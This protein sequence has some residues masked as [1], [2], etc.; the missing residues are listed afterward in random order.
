MSYLA[1]VEFNAENLKFYLWAKD[2]TRRFNLN[3]FEAEKALSPPWS[4]E[5]ATRSK[6][7]EFS[8]MEFH[9]RS[10]K[11]PDR[12]SI[13]EIEIGLDDNMTG[14]CLIFKLFL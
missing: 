6:G 8:M 4:K 12:T 7:V 11:A 1:F 2:Y 13:C 10:E 9:T 14:K 3:L 5:L